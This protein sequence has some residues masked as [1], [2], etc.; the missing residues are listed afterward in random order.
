MNEPVQPKMPF[1]KHAKKPISE[2]PKG[3]LKWMIKEMDLREPLRSQI[4]AA[5]DG[6]PI[7]TSPVISNKDNWYLSDDVENQIAAMF[8][9]VN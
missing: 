1:G 9:K 3:Y 4:K 6:L 5:I 7:P 8:R 2:V